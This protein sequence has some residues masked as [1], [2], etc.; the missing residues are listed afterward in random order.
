M[1]KDAGEQIMKKKEKG[2][3]FDNLPACAAEFIKLVI[4]KMRYRK[5]VRRDVQAELAAHFE[6]ELKDC[7]TDQEKSRKH[8]S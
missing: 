5:K 8:S 6:D 1:T 7:A 3:L 2:K 4:R